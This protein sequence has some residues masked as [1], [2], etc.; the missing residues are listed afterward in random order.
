MA[1]LCQIQTKHNMTSLVE[2]GVNILIK[3]AKT[4]DKPGTLEG[5][6]TENPIDKIPI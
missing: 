5:C 4:F 3:E 2:T 6:H 1:E